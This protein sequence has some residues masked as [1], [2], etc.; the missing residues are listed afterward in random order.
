[1]SLVVRCT[2][3]VKNCSLQL[4]YKNCNEKIFVSPG[5]SFFNSNPCLFKIKI[6]NKLNKTEMKN[7][8]RMKNKS[9][10]EMLCLY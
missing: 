9:I 6:K 2:L 7:K 4:T 5:N 8:M 10:A 1:M 3:I